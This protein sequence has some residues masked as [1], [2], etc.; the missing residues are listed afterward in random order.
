M[1][2]SLN[3]LKNILELDSAEMSAL[4]ALH[5][6]NPNAKMR[7]EFAENYIARYLMVYR[8]EASELI[9][10]EKWGEK[11]PPRAPA[12]LID[13]P[14]KWAELFE[15]FGMKEEARSMRSLQNVGTGVD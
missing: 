3:E 5:G 4:V 10:H 1:F 14:A 7:W 12:R 8:D 9:A 15:M 6:D 13:D 11:A 2:V